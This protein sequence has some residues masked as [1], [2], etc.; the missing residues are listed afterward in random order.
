MQKFGK[1]FGNLAA[2]LRIFGNMEK[3]RNLETKIWKF[4][5]SFG[6]MEKKLETWKKFGNL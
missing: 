1:Q 3:N 5:K 4:K 2:I 6:N